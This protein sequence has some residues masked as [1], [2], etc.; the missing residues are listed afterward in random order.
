VTAAPGTLRVVVNA[1]DFGASREVS[2]GIEA[3]MG[4]G[5]VTSTTILA[6]Q[7]GTEDALERAAARS[8]GAEARSC[9]FGVHLNLCEGP[10]L[11]GRSSLTDAAG[12]LVRKRPQALRA[13]L[14]RIDLG[15]VE[16]ELGAQIARV[17]GAGV[18]V[19][20]LDGHKH[21]HQ[22]PGVADVVM[23]LAERHGVERVRCTRERGLWPPGVRTV[24]GLSRLVRRRRGSVLAR[25]LRARGLRS[26]G[27]T[28]DLAE[29][30]HL[31]A[32]RERAAHLAA[33]ARAGAVVELFCHP[34]GPGKRARETE[35]LLSP[36]FAELVREAGA[37][38]VPYWE[39]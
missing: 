18:A 17:L 35:F 3:C 19:S 4:A 26:P 5:V 10:A 37:A 28:L 7:P 36:A 9:S 22:L 23:A 24:D 13:F 20:H 32:T 30:M 31:P 21:L 14:R 16:R 1:D 2:E 34:G 12:V 15:D 11:T 8:R 33:G 39:V 27:R 6:N 29:L 25:R 38:L